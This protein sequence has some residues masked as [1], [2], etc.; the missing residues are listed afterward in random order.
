MI[1]VVDGRLSPADEARLPA[2]D[3]A[4][5]Y[6]DA[7]FETFR[8]FDRR[9]LALD[10]RLARL[11]RSAATLGFALPGEE[12]FRDDL[13]RAL[14]AYAEP[15][16]YVRVACSRGAGSGGLVPGAT[17]P[18]RSVFVGA[19]PVFPARYAAAGLTAITHPAAMTPGGALSAGAK[20]ACYVEPL[21]ALT[22]A[23][24][25]G[26]DD[27]IGLDVQGCVLEATT[28]NVF[29]WDGRELVAPPASMG[30]LEGIT[31]SLVARLAA[32]SS[33]PLRRR[34]VTVHELYAAEEV[35][36][37]SSIRGVVAVTRID[38]RP[39]GSGLVGAVTGRLAAAYQNLAATSAR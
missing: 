38:G 10:E 18:I 9:V 16:A 7:V 39:V 2:L 1:A 24:R 15:D 33:L 36:L 22:A 26:A 5:W 27:A 8:T 31:A 35:I 20:V 29:V 19:L 37:T 30:I 11:A 32:Q 21:L 12:L 34:V 28:S 17:T 23:R 3:R 4:T 25:A 6:G 14:A 13:A